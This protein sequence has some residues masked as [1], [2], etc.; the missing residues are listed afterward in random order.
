MNVSHFLGKDAKE[1]PTYIFSGGGDIG[2]KKGTPNGPFWATI[3]F[4]FL[5]SPAPNSQYWGKPREQPHHSRWSSLVLELSLLQNLNKTSCCPSMFAVRPSTQALLLGT[6]WAKRLDVE[7]PGAFLL[8]HMMLVCV[9]PC[10]VKLSKLPERPSWSF[11]K[12]S[13]IA[14]PVAIAECSPKTEKAH[15]SGVFELNEISIST[16]KIDAKTAKGTYYV[17]RAKFHF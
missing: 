1:G 14:P 8:S 5:F 7:R 16:I 13:F 15:F 6:I 10:S 3:W 4:S 2:A 11:W 12:P 9:H 17:V